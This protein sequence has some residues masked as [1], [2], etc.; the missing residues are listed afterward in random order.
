LLPAVENALDSIDP[1]RSHPVDGRFSGEK[2]VGVSH[3]A[4]RVSRPRQ[5]AQGDAHAE[6]EQAMRDGGAHVA[7]T[8]HEGAPGLT[9]RLRG[10]RF[11]ICTEGHICG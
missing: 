3:A 8:Q 6:R 5:I 4:T 10:K 11:L 2:R 9:Q 1:S 7:A